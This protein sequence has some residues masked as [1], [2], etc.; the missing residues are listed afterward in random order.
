MGSSISSLVKEQGDGFKAQAQDQ[1]TALLTVA[2]LKYDNFIGQVK[3]TADNT[4]FP[5]N[6]ILSSD[7][8]VH[9]K[10]TQTGEN[11]KNAVSSS[12]VTAFAKGDILDGV[13]A[14]VN[15]GMET[16]LGAVAANQSEHRAYAITCGELGGIMRIDIDIVCYTFTSTALAAV[17]SN[18]ISTAYVISSVDTSKLDKDTISDIVQACYGGVSSYAA[19]YISKTS[20]NSSLTNVNVELVPIIA[21][22]SKPRLRRPLVSQQNFPVAENGASMDDVTG[23]TEM[24]FND[25]AADEVSSLI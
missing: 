11:V 9:A 4:P 18:V 19:L 5:I 8:V 23:T 15:A 13:F 12:T 10:V 1:L 2:E 20:R 24:F 22:D 21:F 14:I 6:K 25:S 3:S 7:H 16:V 17:T